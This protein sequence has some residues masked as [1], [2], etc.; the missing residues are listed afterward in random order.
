MSKINMTTD[1][2]L[3]IQHYPCN[4][5]GKDVTDYVDDGEVKRSAFAVTHTTKPTIR[6]CLECVYRAANM[7][8]ETIK[9]IQ[10]L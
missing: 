3:Q 2:H 8:A 1:V 10:P 4:G 9:K 6:L 5:C 7:L